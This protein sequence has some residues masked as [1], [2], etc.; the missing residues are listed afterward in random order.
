MFEDFFELSS[1]ADNYWSRWKQKNCSRDKRQNINF[2]RQ[3]KK[4]MSEAEKK[5]ADETVEIIKKVL[6]YN[7]N[8]QKKNST[9]IKSW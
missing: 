7:K 1:S 3:N 5:N 8:A 4:K 9:C 6:D 2:Q